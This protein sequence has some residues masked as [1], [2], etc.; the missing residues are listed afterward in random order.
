MDQVAHAVSLNF[1]RVFAQQ[2]LWLESIDALLSTTVS[3]E[4]ETQSD[5]NATSK[6]DALPPEST[7]IGVPLKVPRDVRDLRR[8]QRTPE[9]SSEDEIFLA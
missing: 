4:S 1:G 8:E 2:M 3:S 5:R 7:T 9:S 6:K